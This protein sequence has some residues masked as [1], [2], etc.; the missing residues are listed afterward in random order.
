ML[1]YALWVKKTEPIFVYGNLAKYW[2]L[3]I[4]SPTDIAVNLQ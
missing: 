3:K 4:A 1:S 2:P